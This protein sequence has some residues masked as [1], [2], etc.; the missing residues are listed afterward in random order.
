[1]KYRLIATDMDGTLLDKNSEIT[2]F[3]RETVKKLIES[4]MNLKC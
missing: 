1:M 2:D 3:T 4:E